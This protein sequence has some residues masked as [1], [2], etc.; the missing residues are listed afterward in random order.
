MRDGEIVSDKRNPKKPDEAIERHVAPASFL[1]RKLR[2]QPVKA[3]ANT[4]W[5]FSLMIMAAAD[6]GAAP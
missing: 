5:A 1:R 4:A 3:G 2:P 6:A